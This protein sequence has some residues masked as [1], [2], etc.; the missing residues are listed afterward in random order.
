MVTRAFG[1]G[2]FKKRGIPYKEFFLI[3]VYYFFSFSILLF[4]FSLMS[5]TFIRNE[6]VPTY[7]SSSLHH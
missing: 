1:D 4:T 6:Y 5:S 2:I 3:I 7:S